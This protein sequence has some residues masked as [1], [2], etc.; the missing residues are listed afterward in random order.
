MDILAIKIKSVKIGARSYPM[1]AKLYLIDFDK[2]ENLYAKGSDG[3]F[4]FDQAIQS[5][6][7]IAK[8][9]DVDK[10]KAWLGNVDHNIPCPTDVWVELMKQFIQESIQ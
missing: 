7:S 6:Q 2:V 3:Y 4:Y 5:I 9:V 10:F 8:E 1:T